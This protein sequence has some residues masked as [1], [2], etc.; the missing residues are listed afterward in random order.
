MCVRIPRLLCLLHPPLPAHCLVA[1]KLQLNYQLSLSLSLSQRSPLTSVCLNPQVAVSTPSA[2][3]SPLFGGLKTTAQSSTTSG[4]K[5]T[6]GGFTF[7]SAP[8]VKPSEEPLKEPAKS[9]QFKVEFLSLCI[10]ML[11]VLARNESEILTP[12]ISF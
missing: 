1:S 4:S 6:F 10:L 11:E 2:T 7:S 5:P 8:L 12:H 3:P 9:P